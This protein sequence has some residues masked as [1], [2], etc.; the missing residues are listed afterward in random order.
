MVFCCVSGKFLLFHIQSFA[1]RIEEMIID[2]K[3]IVI[4]EMETLFQ[5]SIVVLL[6][7]ETRKEKKREREPKHKSHP[8]KT[9]TVD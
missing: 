3:L 7:K 9:L 6:W 8:R 5:G 1:E 4:N 2:F